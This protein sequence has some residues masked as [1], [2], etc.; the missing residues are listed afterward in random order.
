[1]KVNNGKAFIEIFSS[2][3]FLKEIVFPDVLM[4]DD[5]VTGCFDA[6]R[7]LKYLKNLDLG[8]SMITQA[9]DVTLADV[10]PSLQLLEKLVVGNIGYDDECQKHLFHA[11]GKLKYLKELDLSFSKIS[12]TG[13]VTLAN[14]LPSLQL[15]EKL[16]LQNIEFDDECQKH[17]FHAVGKLKYLKELDLSFSKISQTGAVTLANVLPSLQLLEKLVFKVIEFDDECPKH[18][19]HA[20][21]KLKY[22]KE[23]DL[24]VSKITQTGAVTL[25]EV[26]PSLQLLEKLVLHYFAFDDECQKH[27]FH[28]VGKLKYLKEL[29][30]GWSEI[31]QTGAVTLAEVLPSLQLL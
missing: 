5:G 28:A 8:R 23:L 3:L 2:L 21:G 10:L 26:L 4:C 25:A 30:F 31:I 17:L 29:D 6:L 27:P 15:L 11:V 16:A 7:S 12:Q 24:W 20:V 9:G 1:M 13:A 22:L 18:L 14:V 19:F